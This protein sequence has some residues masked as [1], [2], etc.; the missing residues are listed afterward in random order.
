MYF[1]PFAVGFV[2]GVGVGWVSLLAL[3][4]AAARWQQKNGRRPK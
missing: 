1:D 2:T 3:V 4:Y